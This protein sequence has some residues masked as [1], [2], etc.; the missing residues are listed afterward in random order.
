MGVYVAPA[1]RSAERGVAFPPATST[2][3]CLGRPDN[4]RLLLAG[5]RRRGEGYATLRFMAGAEENG[6]V[7]VHGVN[8]VEGRACIAGQALLG[9]MSTDCTCQ[10]V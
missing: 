9:G 3:L 1:R 4:G 6:A 7:T 8:R 2:E 5:D 10:G